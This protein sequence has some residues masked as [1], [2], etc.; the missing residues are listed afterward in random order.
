MFRQHG[1]DTINQ[2]DAGA[3][4][5]R[6]LVERRIGAHE[7]TDIGNV[8][9]KNALSLF[10]NFQR[11]RIVKIARRRWIDRQNV[12]VPQVQPLSGILQPCADLLRLF[13]HARREFFRQIKLLHHDQCIEGWLVGRTDHINHLA[14]RR[15]V[16]I[17]PPREPDDDTIPFPRPV[18]CRH[19]KIFVVNRVQGNNIEE[20]SRT[21]E[22]SHNVM[23]AT[24]DNVN[25]LSMRFPVAHVETNRDNVTMKRNTN[26]RRLNPDRLAGLTIHDS[27]RTI[28]R[29]TERSR[30]QVHLLGERIRLAVTD[31]NNLPIEHQL[32]QRGTEA[33]DLF[34]AK[35][36]RG[37]DLFFS[38]GAIGFGLEQVLHR[39]LFFVE[40]LHTD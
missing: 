20:F 5:I 16:L 2:I 12:L 37:H 8:N 23:F 40:N 1:N 7:E 31:R 29:H 22:S 14:L 28:P 6:L 38:P 19:V 39:H 9:A 11:N 25:H 27:P 13:N 10:I 33:R 34:A 26:I 30:H 17:R 3:T 35:P 32:T 18:G 36:Q 4:L 24:L 15:D 21:V